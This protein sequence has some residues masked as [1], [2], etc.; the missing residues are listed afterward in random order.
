MDWW[1]TYN[2]FTITRTTFAFQ[3]LINVPPSSHDDAQS[4]ERPFSFT[5]FVAETSAASTDVCTCRAFLTQANKLLEI[6]CS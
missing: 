2:V 6:V 1:C 3:K 5:S 4:A